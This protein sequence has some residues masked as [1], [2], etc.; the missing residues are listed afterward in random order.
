MITNAQL[1][2][3]Q[4]SANEALATWRRF[5][6]EITKQAQ[7]ALA[8]LQAFT[9]LWEQQAQTAFQAV[10]RIS[11]YLAPSLRELAAALA[12]L[13]PGIQR[14]TALLASRGWYIS[15]EL[16]FPDMLRLGNLVDEQSFDQVDE[17]L[18]DFFT[19]QLRQIEADL[20]AQYPHR[21]HILATAF[22][23]HDRKDYAASVP[24]FLIQADG[25]CYEMLGVQ[26]YRKK[27]G[28]PATA[29]A[30][31][32]HGLS[33]LTAAVLEPLRILVPL[34]QDTTQIDDLDV[35]LNRHAIL[36]GLATQYGSELN[37]LKLISLLAY[38]HFVHLNAIKSDD[39][40]IEQ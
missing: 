11:D 2:Q 8:P 29:A 4:K 13:P 5:G 32:I 21:K 15:S 37:S 7:L 1:E 9:K 39:Q 18:A 34:A 33:P 23:A 3:I 35:A 19:P 6:E 38:L 10:K 36:H 26:L 40:T 16:G 14:S 12:K 17:E 22:A 20:C 25:I 30:V 24:L 27:R 31:D 28:L